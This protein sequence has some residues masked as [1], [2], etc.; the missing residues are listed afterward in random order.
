MK[1]FMM[2]AGATLLGAGV[3]HADVEPSPLDPLDPVRVVSP[4]TLV[5][6]DGI[7]IGEGT[8]FY[9]QVGVETGYESNTFFQADNPTGAGVLRLLV[10]AGIGSLSKSRFNGESQTGEVIFE[11]NAYAAYDQYL[12]SNGDVTDQSGLGLG[13]HGNALVHPGGTVSLYANDGY[14]RILRPVNYESSTNA[15]RDINTALLRLDIHPIGRRLFG[16]IAYTNT[17]D[18]FEDQP[19]YPDRVLNM[20]AAGLSYKLFPLTSL[21]LAVT[22]SYNTGIGNSNKVTSYPFAATLGIST[23]LTV[24]TSLYADGGYTQGFYT[25][26]PDYQAFTGRVYFE[27]RYNDLSAMRLLYSYIH[28]DS[29]NANFFRDHVFMGWL[30]HKIDRFGLYLTPEI[31]FR[32]Y[33][34]LNPPLMGG[35]VRD[36]VIAAAAVGIRYQ[37][38]N[39]VNA[40]VQYRVVD[41]STDYRNTTGTMMLDPSYVRHE[42]FAGV[43]L[44]Y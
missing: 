41:D 21:S 20:L 42:L 29:I 17:V 2:I 25:S 32:E 30:E 24:S 26:G 19:T 9:P 38:R 14:D 6:G 16:T 15:T 31:R 1:R 22:E 28:S 34:G 37:F 40:S 23:A 5:Q 43:R 12:S 11:A 44:A 4:L 13:F 7:K 27:W 35:P 3:A 33:Q 36:D 18:V 8:A 10:E 39:W